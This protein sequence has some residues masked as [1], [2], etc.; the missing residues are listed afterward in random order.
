MGRDINEDQGLT[1]K[2]SYK[3]G[4][5]NKGFLQPGVLQPG[6]LTSRGSYIHGFLQPGV[7]T[8]RG[9]YKQGFLQPEV[10]NQGFLQWVLKLAVLTTTGVTP[11]GS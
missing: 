11:T 3:K 8:T 2:D 6:A 5:Y 4:S 7:L 9:S 10:L 1:T